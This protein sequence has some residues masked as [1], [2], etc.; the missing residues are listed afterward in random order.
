MNEGRVFTFRI[1]VRKAALDD[2]L[3]AAG[4]GQKNVVD[5]PGNFHHI[6]TILRV[7]DKLKPVLV[8]A[9]M[10]VGLRERS[11]E[12][13]EMNEIYAYGREGR[14]ESVPREASGDLEM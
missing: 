10:C 3:R 1:G 14:A 6:N 13:M 7:P 12:V 2:K 5:R 11:Q 9:F 4:R 8:P